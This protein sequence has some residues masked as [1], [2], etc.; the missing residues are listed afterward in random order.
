MWIALDPVPE[1]AAL[2]F[3]VG[4]HR[5]NRWFVPRRFIDQVPYAAAQGRFEIL[6][7]FDEEI[8]ALGHEVVS[9]PVQPGDVVAFHYRTVHSAPG[10]PLAGRRRAVSLRYVGDD[11][12]MATRPW[13][14]SPPFEGV[15]DG[16]TLEGDPRF[17][18]AYTV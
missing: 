4:S 13:L 12:T 18:V 6:P 7:E 15:V 1:E 10:N 14:H 3:I 9:T 2:R 16:A 17:P 8:A 11:A 5:W